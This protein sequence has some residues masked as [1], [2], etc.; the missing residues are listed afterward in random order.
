[1]II[2]N[3]HKTNNESRLIRDFFYLINFATLIFTQLSTK[4]LK[5]I[6]DHKKVRKRK[7]SKSKLTA[8]QGLTKVS[9]L[10]E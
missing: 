7:N 3:N 2:K 9:E 1:M 5:M 4:Q 6:F 10:F 8:E